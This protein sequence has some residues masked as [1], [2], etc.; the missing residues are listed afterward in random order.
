MRICSVEGCM[1]A[2]D[3][4]GFCHRHY[5]RFRLHGDPLA[6][7]K[8]TIPKGT[9]GKF[10]A[11][12]ALR[13]EGDDCLDWPF[14]T[15]RNYGQM[16]ENGKHWIASRYV[17]TIVNGSPPT[18]KHEAAHYC[19][20]ARCVNPKHIRWATAVEN[21]GDKLIH[22]TVVLG[23][24]QANSKLS[25]EDVRRVVELKGSMSNRKIAARFGVGSQTIDSIFNGKTWTHVT[26]GL[27]REVTT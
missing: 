27:Y 19:G 26:S 22:G 23:S 15:V 17:C 18:P 21:A 24:R 5:M 25:E 16:V 1:S 2:H 10:I 12:V 8:S 6:G 11:E 3:A 9:T 13:H 7:R 14:S 4:K 20:N